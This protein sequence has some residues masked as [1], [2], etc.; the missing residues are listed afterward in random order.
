M[1]W[2]ALADAPDY[3][4]IG[5]RCGL[6]IH[7]QVA[8]TKLFCR[9]PAEAPAPDDERPDFRILR[10]LRPAQSEMGEVDAAALA[11]ARRARLFEYLGS[12]GSA[13][14][15]EADEEPPHAASEDALDVALTT[16]LLLGA[17]PVDEI[18]WMRKIVIDGSNTSGFQRTGLVARGGRIDDVGIQTLCLEEDSCRRIRDAP[19]RVVWGLD[20]LGVPLVEIAT[21]PDIRDGEHARRI[22]ARLGAL[23]RATG[24]VMRGLGTI[25]QD[26]NV[27]VRGGVRV[28]VKGVQDLNGVPRVIEWEVRRHLR[29]LEVADTM[30]ARRAT[31]QAFQFAPHAVSTAFAKTEAKFVRSTLQSG[32]VV[33]GH[34]LPGLLGLLGG[35]RK[36]DPRLGRELAAY[37]KR[38]AGVQGIL[39][40]DELPG[41]GIS[42]A[43]VAA[44]RRALGCG[45]EDSFALVAA[46]APVAERALRVVVERAARALDGVLPEVRMAEPDYSTSYLRPMPGAARMYPETDIP[47]SPVDAARL[48]RLRATLPP[49]PEAQ[50]ERLVRT[51][52]ISADEA[53]QIV[54]EGRVA[55]FESLAEQGPPTVAARALLSTLPELERKYPDVEWD[56]RPY[57]AAVLRLVKAGTIAK[58]GV[59]TVLDQIAQGPE[60]RAMPNREQAVLQATEKAGL[61]G[62]DASEVEARARALVAERAEFVRQ[63]GKESVGPLM[64][65]LMKEYRGR[66]DGALLNRVLSREVERLLAPPPKA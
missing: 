7:Q 9:C 19:D 8:T 5:F 64:G 41:L 26:L 58:E 24:R 35:A 36:E 1:G 21:D 39:H 18:Q 12:H 10:R 22:A 63:R 61:T 34:R 62:V 52:G 11:E 59:G 33:L 60:L 51:H 44:V 56:P 28:E 17:G 29:L 57:V 4:A 2:N 42:E 55:E 27:S 66:V 53:K 25:R 43:E 30:R 54:H 31:P 45:H 38:E 6:E 3:A 20:R 37:A 47:P 49:P 50:M 15:V 65:L 40:G 14:L 48:E 46:T 23:L 32:G 13:C 16:A